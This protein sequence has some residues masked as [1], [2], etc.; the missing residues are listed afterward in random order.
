MENRLN[1]EISTKTVYISFNNNTNLKISKILSI[2]TI[3]DRFSQKI[4]SRYCP[5]K[6]SV[7]RFVC[8][9]ACCIIML[10][11]ALSLETVA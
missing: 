3:W 5:S 4:I 7:S 1:G 9:K 2:D 6:W 10:M 8:L 11:M